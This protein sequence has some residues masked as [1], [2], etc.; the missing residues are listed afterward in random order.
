MADSPKLHRIREYN[1]QM[2]ARVR[3]ARDR[4]AADDAL[5]DAIIADQEAALGITAPLVTPVAGGYSLTPSTTPTPTAG[6]LG[7][8]A[9]PDAAYVPEPLPG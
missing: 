1:A 9:T 7:G 8:T 4:E 2:A 6:D 3:A 5:Y